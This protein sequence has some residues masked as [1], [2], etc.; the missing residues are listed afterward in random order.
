MRSLKS[1]LISCPKWPLG[2]GKSIRPNVFYGWRGGEE[3]RILLIFRGSY[4]I[5]R[6]RT[7]TPVD[8]PWFN[9]SVTA[10]RHVSHW[11]ARAPDNPVPKVPDLS[12]VPYCLMTSL[13]FHG[14][15]SRVWLGERA[16]CRSRLLFHSF[17]LVKNSEHICQSQL[18]RQGRGVVQSPAAA[19]FRGHGNHG[20]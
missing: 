11:Y 12:N 17:D 13:T 4:T 2:S 10:M 15:A 20:S 18:A 16:E 9:S 19:A 7:S 5:W 3:N 1:L 8:L 14:G 6:I